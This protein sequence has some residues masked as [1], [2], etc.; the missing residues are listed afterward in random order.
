MRLNDRT[1]L[2]LAIGLPVRNSAELQDLLRQ[3]YDPQS[4]NFHRFLQ[5]HE[6]AARFGPSEA[7][8]QAAIEFARTNGLTIVGMHSNHIVLEV[9]G[10]VSNVERAFQVTL[11]S[12]R[13]PREPREFFAPD[14]APTVPPHVHAVGVEGLSD[15]YLPRPLVQ[16]ARPQGVAPMSGSGP[17]GW[18]AGNDLRHAY[19]PGSPLTGTGQSIGLFEFSDYFKV[20]VT[21]YENTVGISNYVRLKNVVVGNGTPS[22]ANNDEVALD[23]EV[24]I[25][26]APGISQ[27]IVYEEQSI[28]PSALLGRM[29]DDNLAKQLS[30]SWSWSGGP[31]PAVDGIFQQMAVQGQSFFQAA[32]DSDAYT[33]SSV[34]DD[35]NQINTPVDSPYLTSVGGVTL[36]M[37]GL[38]TSWSSEQVWN[39]HSL[40]GRWA[41]IGTGGG[42]STFYPIPEWQTNVNMTTNHGST[43][44]RCIPDV[45]LTA[46][47]IYVAFNNGTNG[48]LAGTSCAA[49]LW[50]GFTALVNQ[51][52]LAANGTTV[53][54]INPALYAIASTTNYLACFHDTT[55]GNNVGTNTAGL[56]PAVAGFDLS[57]G[58]GTPTGSNLV[59]LLAPLT[60]PLIAT[61]P[62][63]L[64]KVSGNNASFGVVALGPAPLTYQWRRGGTNLTDGGNISGSLSAA[65]TLTGATTN[66]AS[67]YSVVVSNNFGSVTSS[68]AALTI[69]LPPGITSALTNKSVECAGNVSFSTAATGTAPLRFQWKAD[70][71]TVAGATNSSVTFNNVHVPNHT[72]SV[73]VTNA[74]GAV[75]ST[76]TLFVQDTTPPVVTLNGANPILLELG[77]AFADPGATAADA[78]AGSLPVTLSGS[79]NSAV[80]GTNFLFYS[81]SDGNGNS[82]SVGRAVVVRDT[83]PPTILWS[84]T[85]L[86]LAADSNC[87]ALMPDVT[88][89]NFVIATDLSGVA[90]ISQN[91]TN[92]AVLPQGTNKVVITLAD[93]FGN[94][95][96]ITNNVRVIDVTPPVIT[97]N[98]AS[99]L[100]LELGSAYL[101]P[102]ASAV[103]QCRGVV[104]VTVIGAVHTAAVGTNVLTYVADDGSGNTNAITRSVRVLDTT[105]PAVLWSFTNLTL[106]ADS[107]CLA[108]TPDLTGTNYIIA[109]DLSGAVFISQ[110]PAIGAPLPRGTNM[111]VLL[112]MDAS[113]NTTAS[114]NAIAVMDVSPPDITLAGGGISFAERGSLFAD[115]SATALD[116]C[117]GPVLVSVSGSVDTGVVGTNYLV[118]TAD[119]GSGNTN[120]ATRMVIVRDTTPP[121]IQWSFTNLTL[122]AGS[123][124]VATIPDLTGTNYLIATDLSGVAA[125][126]QEPT[127]GT[128]LPLGTNNVILSVADTFGNIA[129]ST[130][131]IV[132]VDA[133]PPDITL[134]GGAIAYAELGGTFAEPGATAFDGCAGPVQVSVGGSVNTGVVGTNYLVYS[135]DDGSGNTN[136]AT[137]MVIVRDTTPPAIHWSFTNLTLVAG[138]NCVATIPDLTGTNYLIATDLSGVAAVSQEPTNGS[139]LPLGT[140]SVVLSVVDTFGNIA[141]STNE[142]VVV[143]ATPPDIALAG[144]AIAYAE[145]GGTFAEPGATATDACAG[146]VAVSVSGSVDTANLSTNFLLYAADDGNGNTNVA[147]RTVIGTR[148]DAAGNYLELHQSLRFDGHKLRRGNAGCYRH[149]CHYRD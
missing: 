34:L 68:L 121:A 60:V 127:N 104:P 41:N 1:N 130:N 4:P 47:G 103:D 36:T 99:I 2:T 55:S 95:S 57:T 21:N 15:Y 112:V 105:P 14:S 66:D 18:L 11:H 17:S 147:T 93:S 91:P 20:D 65:L 72:I 9:G 30:S 25:A 12:Y 44:W 42:I 139:A 116:G 97:L 61:P 63:S 94:V 23:I 113:G 143:D 38:G 49:P 111:V 109:S 3:L 10:S 40:G 45:A 31:D 59:N 67:S 79:V 101:E 39:Y 73:V 134:A 24:A 148:H 90:A 7:D 29:A 117:A 64:T 138:S 26:I 35:P 50:A 89:T 71:L 88:T 92:G 53:G 132:V 122:I 137:R 125:V 83:T 124:C 110:S 86:S 108:A 48:G 5:P 62:A 107:N 8:Y 128:A 146:P 129:T 96:R 56:F 28:N 102:G 149:Q 27:V 118:Y 16:S 54:F 81:A 136:V 119:D 32:G 43:V 78:C 106:A 74:Y 140:N 76:A 87:V 51:Q 114:T 123:N 135:A 144:G 33:G 115:P 22:T 120:V 133:T 75:T 100:S 13:H 70:G 82:N 141:T 126:S 69:V 52:S 142:I 98:G 37:F 131:E 6:F 58:L 77:A 46:D 84:F 85:N 80:T 19:A 145:L